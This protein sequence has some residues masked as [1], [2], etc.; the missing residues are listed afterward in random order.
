[1]VLMKGRIYE[2][3]K[4]G[5]GEIVGSG[6]VGWQFFL[7]SRQRNT[8]MMVFSRTALCYLK[9]YVGGCAPTSIISLR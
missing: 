5:R 8:P 2:K 9:S 6:L 3:N 4:K 1:M 7:K